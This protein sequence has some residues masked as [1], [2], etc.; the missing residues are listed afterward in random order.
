MCFYFDEEGGCPCF[1]P[2]SECL[3][4]FLQYVSIYLVR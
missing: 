1:D 4:E 3:Y 2:S